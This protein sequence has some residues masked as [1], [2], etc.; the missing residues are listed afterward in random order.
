M[1]IIIIF[2]PLT[3]AKSCLNAVSVWGFKVFP[4]LF[5]FF[6]FVNL[7]SYLNPPKDNFMDK[8]FNKT[9]HTPNGSFLTFFLS[10]LSGYP[11]GAKLI[12]TM[13][14]NKYISSNEAKKML[15]FCSIS[16]PMFIIGTV[17]VMMLQSFK[18]GFII[19][20]AN[21]LAVTL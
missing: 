14:E 8:F 5:P 21:S 6:I 12:C 13:Y 4:V 15:S 19:L 17:G 1:C 2:N 3:Y 11:M 20:I 9:Y 10:V 18:A 7:I 16:G